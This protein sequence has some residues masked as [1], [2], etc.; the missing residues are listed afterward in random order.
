[1]RYIRY[2]RVFREELDISVSGEL[3]YF[4][5]IAQPGLQLFRFF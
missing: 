1:V 3:G 2:L 5:Q 4:P